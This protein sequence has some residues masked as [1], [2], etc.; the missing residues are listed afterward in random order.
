[1]YRAQ[2]SGVDGI[3]TWTA[4]S[5]AALLPVA[6]GREAGLRRNG[7]GL[8][9]KP[10]LAVRGL[11]GRRLRIVPVEFLSD[12]QAA[13]YGRFHGCPSLAELERFFFLDDADLALTDN[14]CILGTCGSAT[15]AWQAAAASIFPCI[16]G[17]DFQSLL[18]GA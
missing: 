3:F 15:A 14:G 5:T 1:M 7:A 16:L 9:A 12:E 13:V 8:N 18:Q 17:S 2:L 10:V 11:S 6:G 4:C